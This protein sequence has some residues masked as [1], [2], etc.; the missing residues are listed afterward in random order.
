MPKGPTA[1]R[2]AQAL[3][4][5]ASEKNANQEWLAEIQE[6]RSALKEEDIKS[7]LSSPRVKK[8]SKSDIVD[9]LKSNFDALLVNFIGLLVAR[10]SINLLPEIEREYRSLLDGSLGRVSAKVI[11]AVKLSDRQ[12]NQLSDGLG[13]SLQKEVI[14]EQDID[15][16]IIGGILIRVGDKIIDGSVHSKLESLK[17]KLL[18]ESIV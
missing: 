14:I 8:Q 5:L 3:F 17:S 12:V 10:N 16:D 9:Q 6:L 18:R 2:Y 11:T 7:F 4:L 15:P 13:S 1:R